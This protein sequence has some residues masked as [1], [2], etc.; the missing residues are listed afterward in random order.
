MIHLANVGNNIWIGNREACHTYKFRKVLHIY[1][2][3]KPE[4]NCDPISESIKGQHYKLDYLDGQSLIPMFDNLYFTGLK[5]F[6]SGN[7]EI[8]IH[9]FAGTYRSPTL[10]ILAKGLRGC[11][12]FNAMAEI[13]RATRS[14]YSLFPHFHDV[15]ISE[16][17]KMLG[18]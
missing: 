15:P 7:D 3:G 14:R 18:Y 6:L 8:L 10:A 11:D 17:C 5:D 9:C 13:A 16:I 1:W 12:P 4:Y 2:S